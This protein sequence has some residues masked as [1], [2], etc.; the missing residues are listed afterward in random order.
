MSNDVYGQQLFPISS[1]THLLSYR[2]LYVED[3]KV[4]HPEEHQE[5]NQEFIMFATE[6]YYTKKNHQKNLHFKE[7]TLGGRK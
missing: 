5:S 2:K 1:S 4:S 3:S 7:G 6:S